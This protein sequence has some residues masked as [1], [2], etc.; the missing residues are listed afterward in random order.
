[1]K[2]ITLAASKRDITGRK[3]DALRE[4]GIIPASIY[5]RGI[6]SVTIQVNA[7]EF[8]QVF[9]EA[10]ETG[11]VMLQVGEEKGRPTLIKDRQI[12]PTTRELL[13]IDFYQVNLKEAIKTA[14]PVVAVGEA[15]AVRDNLGLLMSPQ[16]TLEIEA[17]PTDI[18]E[19]VEVDITNLSEVGNQITVA[20]ISV[21]SEVTVLTDPSTVLFSIGELPVEEE[22]PVAEETTEP[23]VIGSEEA[24]S[25]ESAETPAE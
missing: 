4:S 21:P 13:H 1:M 3:V 23:E 5:G 25:E 18:P 7:K 20:D 2:K 11:V 8:D 10:G 24:S 9:K 17:L 15:V 19:N 6:P 14:I 12:N 22:E 16:S